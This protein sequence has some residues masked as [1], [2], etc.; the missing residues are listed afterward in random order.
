MIHDHDR[1]GWFG[2]SDTA[3]IMGNW[4]T[5]TF[6]RF[7]LQKLGINRDHF[8]TIE[9]QTGTALEHRILEHIGIW[10]MDRQIR[11]RKLRLRV[12]LDGEDATTIYEVK[13]HKSAVFKVSRPYWMQ[14]QVEMFATGKQLQIVSYHV[15][16]E[17]YQNWF[18][19]IDDNRLKFHPI[20]YDREWVTD[21][22][23]PRL[24]RLADYLKKGAFP[25]G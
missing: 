1:S 18:R 2:A 3:A 15:E 19:E 17:D 9:T 24:R 22:Y 12:N 16:P 25:D 20:E 13:T 5:K 6:Q 8:E 11:K 7:W 14:A 4:N 10:K 21:E 23:L